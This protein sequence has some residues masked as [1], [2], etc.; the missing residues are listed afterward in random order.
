MQYKFL[1]FNILVLNEKK[2][3]Y[4]SFIMKSSLTGK[5]SEDIKNR[6]M[7][8]LLSSSLLK[9]NLLFFEKV[10]SCFEYDRSIHPVLVGTLII[11]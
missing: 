8:H 3:L 1:L 10:I 5:F 11:I 2:E 6:C 9:A 4:F 7:G